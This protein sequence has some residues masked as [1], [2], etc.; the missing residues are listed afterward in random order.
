MSQ[1]DLARRYYNVPRRRGEKGS[2]R[3]SF[4]SLHRPSRQPLTFIFQFNL[5]EV[6]RGRKKRLLQKKNIN[7]N[8]LLF[9]R[10]LIRGHRDL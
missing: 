4:L 7:K 3:I 9:F 6:L 2:N 10:I 5:I 1:S 8:D